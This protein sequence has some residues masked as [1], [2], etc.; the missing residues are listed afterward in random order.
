MKNL[1]AAIPDTIDEELFEELLRAGRVRIERHPP[2]IKSDFYGT[3]NST[4]PN[5]SGGPFLGFACF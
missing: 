1:Y 4:I 5:V 3:V 2:Q